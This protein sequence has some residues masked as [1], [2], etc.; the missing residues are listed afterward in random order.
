M[1]TPS[2]LDNVVVSQNGNMSIVE[3][4]AGSASLTSNQAA[5][6][7]AVQDGQPVTLYGANASQI[8]NL[9]A[10]GQVIFPKNGYSIMRSNDSGAG[11]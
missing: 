11:P 6:Q 4:K 8:P 3:A 2:V 9:P 7:S 5:I 10:D 1:E